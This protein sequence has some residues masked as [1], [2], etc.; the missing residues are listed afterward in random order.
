MSHP[1]AG[2][3]HDHGLTNVRAMVK[4][5]IFRK[6]SMNLRVMLSFNWVLSQFW[7]HFSK[8]TCFCLLCVNLL[9]GLCGRRQYPSEPD[10]GGRT[11]TQTQDNLMSDIGF[12]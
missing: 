9:G 10:T 6:S 5:N 4:T 7:V 1:P 8:S 2:W 12:N 3:P 11:D